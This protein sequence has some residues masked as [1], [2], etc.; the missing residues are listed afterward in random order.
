MSVVVMGIVVVIWFGLCL[1]IVAL[2][3]SAKEG[4]GERLDALAPALS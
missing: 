4:D 3:A 1:V 2:C